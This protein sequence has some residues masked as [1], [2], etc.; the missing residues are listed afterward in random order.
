MRK[1]EGTAIENLALSI[2]DK[3]NEIH[4]KNESGK[5]YAL[6]L[7]KVDKNRKAVLKL[8]VADL[9]T[10]ERE[11]LQLLEFEPDNVSKF[12]TVDYRKQ[13]YTELIFGMFTLGLFTVEENKKAKKLENLMKL[14]EKLGVTGEAK[15][16]DNKGVDRNG[17]ELLEL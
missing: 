4:R 14:Q 11:T 7:K 15:E 17:E 1:K 5:V 10:K 16:E 6:D 3:L 12:L 9:E 13:M 8:T 2:V